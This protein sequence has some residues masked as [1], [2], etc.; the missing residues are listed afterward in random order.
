MQS[1]HRNIKV[2]RH[3]DN[4]LPLLW[5]HH[6]KLVIIDQKIGFMGGLDI[7][8]GRWDNHKHLLTDPGDYWDGAD[9]NNFRTKDI[10]EP[11]KF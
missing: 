8:Y 7:C 9:Y 3:P 5:S 2:L 10:Y 11:R 4:V 1:L 6:E